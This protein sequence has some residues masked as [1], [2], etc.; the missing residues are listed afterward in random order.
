MVARHVPSWSPHPSI[1]QL[2]FLHWL[3]HV[4]RKMMINHQVPARWSI[5]IWEKTIESK[6]IILFFFCQTDP[7]KKREFT[8][9][10]WPNYGQLGWRDFVVLSILGQ[11]TGSIRTSTL[12]YYYGKIGP[13]SSANKL[14][15]FWQVRFAMAWWCVYHGFWLFTI[16]GKPHGKGHDKLLIKY[17]SGLHM[18]L[19]AY[20]FQVEHHVEVS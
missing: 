10:S 13:N 7:S 20:P 19:M 2:P 17:V 14:F 16:S 12:I 8:I 18:F 4:R 11:W 3:G 6:W 15:L 1:C 5:S 9:F